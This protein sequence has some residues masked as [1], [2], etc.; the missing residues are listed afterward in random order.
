MDKIMGGSSLFLNKRIIT[1]LYFLFISYVERGGTGFDGRRKKKPGEKINKERERENKRGLPVLGMAGE[2]NPGLVRPPAR[3]EKVTGK[4][5][6]GKS[7]GEGD[8]ERRV[9]RCGRV[10]GVRGFS[11]VTPWSG[12]TGL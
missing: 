6:M 9:S 7:T 11:A 5:G 4:L 2:E 8:R 1:H 10:S 12:L 3:G